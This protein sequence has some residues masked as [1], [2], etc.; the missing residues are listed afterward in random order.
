MNRWR[1]S[2]PPALGLTSDGLPPAPS[3]LYSGERVGVRGHSREERNSTNGP[4]PQPSPLSTGERELIV[5]SSNRP[6]PDIPAIV[7]PLK[8]NFL[9]CLIRALLSGGD[10]VAQCRHGQHTAA[11]SDYRAAVHFGAGLEDFHIGHGV[12]VGDA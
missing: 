8:V 2:A 1:Y 9:D 10:G 3:P 6:F 5:A 4:S 11:V 7:H 12:G